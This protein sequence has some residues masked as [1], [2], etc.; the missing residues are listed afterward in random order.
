M[1]GL[2]LILRPVSPELVSIR[3]VGVNSRLILGLRLSS[4]QIY[5]RTYIFLM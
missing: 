2:L 4:L 5:V 3:D 1:R